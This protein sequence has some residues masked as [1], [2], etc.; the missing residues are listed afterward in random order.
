[1]PV[2]TYRT[3]LN[4]PVEKVFGWHTRPGALERLTPPWEDVRVEARE[5]GMDDGGTVTLRLRKG[6]ANLRWVVRHTAYRENEMFRDEQ[7]SGPFQSWKHTHR[8]VAL[9]ETRT[10]MVDEVEWEPP[11]G[12]VGT[13]VGGS[14]IEGDLARLFRF[15]HARLA[16][17]L[18]RHAHGGPGG[19]WRIG[20]TGATG[21]VGRQLSAFLTTG[22]HQVVPFLRRGE[23]DGEF[24]RWNPAAGLLSPEDV[25]GLDAVV[26]LAG[27]SIAG[28]R[29]SPE[30]KRSILESRV[31]G[32]TLLA[33]TLAGLQ[34]PPRVLVSSSAVGFYGNRGDKPLGED[35]GS[36]KGFLAEVCRQWEGATLAAERRGIRTVHLRTGMVITPAGGA[37]D[38][39]LTPFK[40]GAGGRLGSGRQYM[41]WIDLDD[42]LGLVLHALAS[43]TI[44]GALNATAPE[45]VTNSTFTTILGRVLNRPTVLPVPGL[46]IRAMFGEMGQAL[47][48]EGAR[49]LPRKAQETGFEFRFPS[50]E[51]SL[52]FQLGKGEDT[53]DVS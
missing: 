36:G 13:A 51:D 27:E 21:L 48:L 5:G 17:D 32:T 31:E 9:G 10:A 46:A 50:L 18:A 15:R 52:R 20:I 42:L 23:T 38:Q 45:P 16:G 22:G 19:S 3:E 35:A 29:W 14:F 34:R 28:D 41:S 7:V 44:K 6:P 43:P 1:M 26:H 30:K 40:L 49:V 37:L 12:A 11:L 53:E 4:H 24:I 47:L 2:F 39:M 33:E 8:F 25:E